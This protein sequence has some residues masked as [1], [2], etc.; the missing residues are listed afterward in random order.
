MFET[1]NPFNSI[2]PMFQG[3]MPTLPFAKGGN[4]C[5]GSRGDSAKA[6]ELK[7]GIRKFWEQAI[8]MQRSTVGGS[9]DQWNL[10]FGHMMDLQDSFVASMPDELPSLPGFS[11]AQ[12]FPMSPKSFMKELKKFQEMANAHFVEQADSCAEFFFQ[13][14][15]QV[16]DIV[17][18]AAENREKDEGGDAPSEQ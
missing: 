4:C 16:C 7:S 9:K 13:G 12:A 14:Q 3:M 1:T 11:F 2:M 8:D 10:F 17:C 5:G 18:A 6:E 15:E